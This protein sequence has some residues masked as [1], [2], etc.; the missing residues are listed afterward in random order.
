M[1]GLLGRICNI[2][3]VHPGCWI[4]CRIKNYRDK[5]NKNL[6]R[7]IKKKKKLKKMLILS[8]CGLWKQRWFDQIV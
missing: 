2:Y 7:N 6:K 8:V 1:L 3:P 5:T 4:Y